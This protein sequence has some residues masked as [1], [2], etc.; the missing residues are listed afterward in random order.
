MPNTLFKPVTSMISS[1]QEKI[2]FTG[3][4][5]SEIV[6]TLCDRTDTLSK[7][8]NYFSSFGLPYEYNALSSGSTLAKQYPEIY[9]I[10][11]DKI[12]I[13]PIPKE[14]YSELLDGRSITIDVPQ[15][16][17][18]TS[19]S[20]KTIYSS[21]YTTLTKTDSNPIL[22]NNIAF[23]FSD[24]LNLPYTG[25]TNGGTISHS[26]NTTWGLGLS[27]TER[28][29][30]VSYADLLTDDINTDKRPWSSV[31][32]SNGVPENYPTNTNQGYNYDIPLGF[33]ALDKGFIVFTH[34]SIVDNIPWSLGQEEHTNAP[35]VAAGTS[36]IYF[37]AAPTSNLSYIDISI[38]YK[39]TVVCLA[40][41]Q[42]F[43][44]S[45]NPSWDFLYNY[46]EMLNQTNGF[47]SVYVTEVGLY[48]RLT[49]LVAVAK[50]SEPLEKT[51]TNIINFTL[52][53]D[54]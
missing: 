53:I 44:F 14:N 49:E 41:P 43:Y 15:L 9:Q 42:E 36:N 18:A 45:N 52:N 17:G 37:S 13:A 1:R 24:E 12:V 51:Y 33:V 2:A 54:V 32:L 8:A 46:N 20:A 5:G 3:M 21:T 26:A 38:E 28:P 19:I 11:R 34:P 39:T 27:Y 35:N 40:L 7:E 22:G 16:S 25:K 29:P 6:Y 47:E 31:T 30:A 23:L 10:N 4:N 50:L 48:N